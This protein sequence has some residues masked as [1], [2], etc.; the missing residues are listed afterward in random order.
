LLD[1]SPGSIKATF[2]TERRSQG[3]SSLLQKNK[4]NQKY[5]YYDLSQRQVLLHFILAMKFTPL[6]LPSSLSSFLLCK[7]FIVELLFF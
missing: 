2:L 6:G 4:N 1:A 5:G 3:C 7:N